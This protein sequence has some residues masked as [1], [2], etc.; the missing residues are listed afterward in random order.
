MEIHYVEFCPMCDKPVDDTVRV[1]DYYR[2]AY[3]IAAQEGYNYSKNDYKNWIRTALNQMEFPGND[4][5]ISIGWEDDEEDEYGTALW[6]YYMGLK[7][8]FGDRKSVV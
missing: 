3:Y 5:Y 1:L 8:Y 2:T 4:C 6:Q 7:K